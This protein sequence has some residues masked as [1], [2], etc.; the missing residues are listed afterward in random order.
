MELE[1][2]QRRDF[3]REKQ[4]A[5][6]TPND[7]TPSPQVNPSGMN[8]LRSAASPSGFA[9]TWDW[10]KDFET[11]VYVDNDQGIAWIRI[12]ECPAT[13]REALAHW[14]DYGMMARPVIA[15]MEPQDAVYVWDYA[16]FLEAF[17]SGGPP[18]KL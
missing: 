13:E 12:S 11:P 9:H 6:Q 16:S 3:A 15:G 18:T 8:G 17:R 10:Q 5:A 2:N 7:D 4:G 1:R 14:V